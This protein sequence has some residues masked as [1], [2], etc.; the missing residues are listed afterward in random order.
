MSDIFSRT[1]LI[2]GEEAM[3]ILA[4]SRVA[5]F[6]VGGVGGYTVE[7]LAR[8][9]VGAIDLIDD[10]KVCVTNINRQIIALGSTVG[11]Y[12]VDAAEKRIHDINPEC[13]VT[14]HKMFYMPETADKLDFSQYDY[15]V[16]AIDT[17]TGKIEIIMQAQKA[18]VP[19]I[20]SMGAGNKVDPT[21][22]EV[23]DI[24]KTSVC[25]LARVMRYQLKR[26][27]VKKLKVVYSKEQPI[28]PQGKA[29]E[30]GSGNTDMR[31]GAARRS[32]PG[33]N[34]FVPSV[35]GLIIGGEVIKDLIRLKKQ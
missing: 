19:V 31:T 8:S 22:F 6:G 7:A 28:A 11:M 16:D 1:Q 25:P 32:T 2:F 9:G 20:S 17:V 34:A 10:D 27:G 13:T 24:Y 26:R 30:D 14:C 35:A 29:A 21:A 23:A 4:N 12:K 33:S 5:V 18:G 3:E 15:V